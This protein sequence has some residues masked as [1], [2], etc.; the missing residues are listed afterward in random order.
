MAPAIP[1]VTIQPATGMKGTADAIL[2]VTIALYFQ[3]SPAMVIAIL[4]AIERSATLMGETA[5]VLR[6]VQTVGYFLRSKV[7]EYATVNVITKTALG[8]VGTVGATPSV[9]LSG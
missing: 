5:P 2:N 1:I 8:T 3:C 4:H 9:L 6:H 7:T